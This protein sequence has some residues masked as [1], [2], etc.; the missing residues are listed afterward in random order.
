MP[1]NITPQPYDP[2]PIKPNYG[3]EVDDGHYSYSTKTC[4]LVIKY[5]A[6]GASGDPPSDSV[7]TYSGEKKEI[8]LTRMVKGQVASMTRSGYYFLG[9][10]TSSSG[11]VEYDPGQIISKKWEANE[12]GT[13]TVKLYAIWSNQGRIVYK[14]GQYAKEKDDAWHDKYANKPANQPVQLRG[15]IFTRVG[16]T[17]VGWQLGDAT[18]VGLVDEV[19]T[20]DSTNEVVLYP[21]W[22]ANTYTL[23][24]KPNGATGSDIVL[25]ATYDSEITI[26]ANNSFSKTGYHVS[27]WNEK[28]DGTESSWFPGKTYTFVRTEDITLYAIWA[29]NEYHVVYNLSGTDLVPVNSYYEIATYGMPFFTEFKPPAKQNMSFAGWETSDGQTLV[30]TDFC[31]DSYSF[32]VDPTW[33]KLEDV[34]LHPLWSTD[35]PYGKV[36]FGRKESTEYGIVVEEPPDYHWP[37]KDVTNTEIKGRTGDILTDDERLG[38]VEK[39]YKIAAYDPSGF[40]RAASNVSE[41]LHRYDGYPDYVRLEDTYEPDV[42]MLGIYREEN[43]LTNILNQAGRAE[44]KFFCKPQKYLITGNKRIEIS[45]SPTTITNP[46]DHAALP[47][48]KLMGTGTIHFKG[49]PAR[50]AY[51]S[52]QTPEERQVDLTVLYNFNEITIDCATYDAVDINGANANP[53]I[54]LSEKIALYPGDNTITFEGDFE[55]ILIVPR[56][57]RV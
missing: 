30:K 24:F 7:V 29:G 54:S 1:A 53:Y 3:T 8:T 23:T 40:H 19:V 47:L 21:E 13:H 43:S 20:F 9:W 37:E 39:V 38:N 11:N 35:Y 2:D 42:Y 18:H 10:S 48:I 22:Q 28:D 45:Q 49:C 16:Y 55:S 14:P 32:G 5:Y 36:F 6:N 12:S 27:V 50:R 41:F 4:K 52:Y 15:A 44:I 46:T 25:S 56:W 51:S 17:L 33:T 31:L 26:P 57:W 34:V